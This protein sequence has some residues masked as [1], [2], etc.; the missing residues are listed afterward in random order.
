[1]ANYPGQYDLLFKVA[2]A[3]LSTYLLLSYAQKDVIKAEVTAAITDKI[4]EER[5]QSWDF[6]HNKISA[7]AAG[8]KS[9]EEIR[10][11][12]QVQV[13]GIVR[14][15]TRLQL[16]DAVAV[17]YD[18]QWDC[19]RSCHHTYSL[20]I[21]GASGPFSPWIIPSSS[22]PGILFEMRVSLMWITP[23]VPRA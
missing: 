9:E 19:G 15:G 18:K 17:T 4:Y 16:A 23:P 5:L 3:S 6:S 7:D 8:H 1:M 2:D 11:E 20:S 13:D 14:S 21:A 12:L 10:N 22:Y